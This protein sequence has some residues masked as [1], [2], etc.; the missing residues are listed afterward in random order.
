MKLKSGN[1]SEEILLN[2]SFTRLNLDQICK[3]I[4]NLPTK[5]QGVRSVVTANVDHMVRLKKDIKLRSAYDHAWLRTIDGRPLYAY[6]RFR[7][8][9]LHH[10]PGADIV[11]AV[12]DE[13]LPGRH[14]PYFVVSDSLLAEKL[15][16]WASLR[17]FDEKD[18]GIDVPPMG[19]DALRDCQLELAKKVRNHSP[20]HL[21]M[22]IG[23]PRSEIWLDEHRF[24]LGDIYA[25][26]IG[27]ALA[28]HVGTL[29][30]APKYLQKNGLEWLWRVA[31]EPRRLGKRYFLHSWTF[32]GILWRDLIGL[33]A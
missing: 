29:R 7:G 17:G 1:E 28:F 19:F 31:A 30:R 11:P 13:M 16:D 2:V 10:A 5:G 18:V 15:L 14:R 6:A 12:L 3:L 21:F 25:L 23:C 4:V 33:R 8:L 26:S 20:T 27:S 24:E 32:L 9:N 22:G